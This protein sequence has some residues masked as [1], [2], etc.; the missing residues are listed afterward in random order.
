[1]PTI[2]ESA[3]KYAVK[4][5]S[6]ERELVRGAESIDRDQRFGALAEAAG[7]FK[8]ARNLPRRYDVDCALPRMSPTLEI[9]ANP[10]HQ[11]LD[12]QTVR[13]AVRSLRSRLAA[14]YGGRDQL[15]AASKL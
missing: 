13:E 2:R 8:I 9:L 5:F 14:A 15:S 10:G 4:W 3:N 11:H 7:Y 1:M 6:K 12:R